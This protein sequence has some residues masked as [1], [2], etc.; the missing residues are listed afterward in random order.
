MNSAAKPPVE[1]AA[2]PVILSWSG[3]KDSSLALAAL[4]DDPA[5]EVVALLTSVTPAYDRISI[6]GVR[7]ALLDA[8]TRSLGLRLYEIV[9]EPNCSNEA[10]HAAVERTMRTIGDRYPRVRRVA[11]GDLFLDDV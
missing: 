5:F 6:H 9:L 8:Q 2:E 11:Y 10:Y 3:G 4:R 7:R 1:S